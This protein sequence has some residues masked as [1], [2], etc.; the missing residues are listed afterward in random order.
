MARVSRLRLHAPHQHRRGV[1]GLVK[2]SSMAL[3]FGEQLN[4]LLGLW[5]SYIG[6]PA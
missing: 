6:L 5:V 3:L 1:H 4:Y 2:Y